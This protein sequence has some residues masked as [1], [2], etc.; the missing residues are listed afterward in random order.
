MAIVTDARKSY[1]LHLKEKGLKKLET[2]AEKKREKINEGIEDTNRQ[3]KLLEKTI[4]KPYA[5]KVISTHLR[6][7]KRPRM[8]K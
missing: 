7:R 2:D 8:L 5:D 4:A 3:I 6:R 1:F